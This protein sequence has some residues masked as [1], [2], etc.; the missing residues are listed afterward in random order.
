M[1]EAFSRSWEATKA[2]LEVVKKDKELMLYPLFTL[3]LSVG[4]I[5][6]MLLPM[7][8]AW[9]FNATGIDKIGILQWVLLFVLYFGLSVISTFFSFCIVYTAKTRFE[10]KNVTISESIKFAFSKIGLI[11]LWGVLAATIGILFRILDN[12]AERMGE[13]GRFLMD[14]FNS[15]LGM[16]WSIITMFVTPVMVYEGLTPFKAIGKSVEVL[17]KTWGEVLIKEVSIGFIEVLTIVLGFI[18]G[19][20]LLVV[21]SMFGVFGALLG[22]FLFV[23]LMGGIIFFFDVLNKVFNTALYV[24]ATTGKVPEGFDKE[25]ITKAFSSKKK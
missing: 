12:I 1:F 2:T 17:K 14:I 15:L 13:R 18:V 8:F 5:I 7:I 21:L 23:V 19:I 4:F 24:Y 9:V 25:V 11:A 22:I 16:I 6:L 20:V 10:G 3:V